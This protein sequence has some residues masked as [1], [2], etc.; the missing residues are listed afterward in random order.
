MPVTLHAVIRRHPQLALKA[1]YLLAST[2]LAAMA[3]HVWMR[4]S[5]CLWCLVAA[6]TLWIGLSVVSLA[7]PLIRRWGH[8]WP[9]VVIFPHHELL[10][11]DITVPAS[12]RVEPG[13]YVCLWLP[14]AGLRIA[15]QLPLFYISSW[16]DTPGPNDTGT[17]G[18]PGLVHL[19]GQCAQIDASGHSASQEDTLNEA[20][21]LVQDDTSLRS[22]EQGEDG[23]R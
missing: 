14:Q 19:S 11:M 4:R 5:K 7:V 10:S 22:G 9:S 13:Q 6:A 1:H 12:W 2:G 15:S 8:A 18:A 3:Y 20:E 23:H 17:R 21:T 16:E